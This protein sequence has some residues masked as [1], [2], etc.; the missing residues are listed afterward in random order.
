MISEHYF[1][2]E[3]F[4]ALIVSVAVHWAC[5]S[6]QQYPYLKMHELIC[7][8]CIRMTANY[9]RHEHVTTA[10]VAATV[11]TAEVAVATRVTPNN[12]RLTAARTIK[13]NEEKNP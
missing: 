4:C 13:V 9:T 6:V 12:D 1:L 7:M 2:R 8:K 3:D 5:L 10:A 11:A